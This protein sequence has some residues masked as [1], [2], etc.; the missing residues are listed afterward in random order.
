MEGSSTGWHVSRVQ[1]PPIESGTGEKS[2]SELV[3]VS[4]HFSH[5][6][7]PDLRETRYLRQNNLHALTN[8]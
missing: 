1:I 3:R 5:L 2:A 4:G 8:S 7:R 6:G